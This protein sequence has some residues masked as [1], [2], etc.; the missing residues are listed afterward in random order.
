MK[1]LYEMI[2]LILAM[3]V[4]CYLFYPMMHNAAHT[5]PD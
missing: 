2:P 4:C 3:P 5:K 1:W